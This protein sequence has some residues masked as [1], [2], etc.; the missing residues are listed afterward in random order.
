MDKI[1]QFED[2]V[3]EALSALGGQEALALDHH[4]V[5]PHQFLGIEVNPRAAAIAV[6]DLRLGF[7]SHNDAAAGTPPNVVDV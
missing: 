2:E 3:L 7:R 1:K 4:R 5:D 6:T